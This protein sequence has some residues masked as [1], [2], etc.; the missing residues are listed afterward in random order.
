MNADADADDEEVVQLVYR[1]QEESEDANDPDTL[2][3]PLRTPSQVMDSVNLL[4]RFAG[5]HEGAEDALNSLPSYKCAIS[6]PTKRMQAKIT[7][8]FTRQ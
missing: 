6:L 4:R 3:V 2:E 8:F 7:G 5:A 1:A